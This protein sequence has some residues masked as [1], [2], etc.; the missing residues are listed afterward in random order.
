MKKGSVGVALPT[1]RHPEVF[2]WV[3]ESILAQDV[4][5]LSVLIFDNGKPDGFG[6]IAEICAHMDDSRVRYSPNL[7]NIGH[8]ANYLQC[9]AALARFDFGIVLSA[10][11]ALVPGMLSEMIEKSQSLEADVVFPSSSLINVPQTL[12][13][14]F[15]LPS[16]VLEKAQKKGE[17]ILSGTDLVA[18]FFGPLNSEGA[19]YR[20]SFAGSLAKGHIFSH[21]SSVRSNYV[22]H[23][24]EYTY[25]MNMAIKAGKVVL[26]DSVGML[27][28]VGL[29]R[30]GTERSGTDWS[31]FEPILAT[32]QFLCE[33]LNPDLALGEESAFEQYRKEHLKRLETYSEKFGQFAFLARLFRW[34]V[35]KRIRSVFVIQQIIRFSFLNLAFREQIINSRSWLVQRKK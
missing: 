11:I 25:S 31:R 1:Y 20:F 35:E 19:Y 27:A 15:V 14:S 17:E 2:K 5:D 3:L 33:N 4:D 16:E 32:Y 21:L 13:H 10:D 12:N 24:W 22:A 23:G 6:A 8:T 34:V 18:E 30:Y 28:T 9:F 29:R 7:Y 26:L